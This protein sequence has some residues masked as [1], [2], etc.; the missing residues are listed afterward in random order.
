MTLE[1]FR[2]QSISLTIGIASD[3][4]MLASP[5]EKQAREEAITKLFPVG[6]PSLALEYEMYCR[7]MDGLESQSK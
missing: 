4:Q 6:D 3:E 1:E 2:L 7:V 5:D